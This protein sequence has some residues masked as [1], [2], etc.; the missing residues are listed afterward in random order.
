MNKNA[1]YAAAALAVAVLG[2]SIALVGI[3]RAMVVTNYD[4]SIYIAATALL[5]A[6]T[7]AVTGLI[8]PTKR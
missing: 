5:Y 2:L 3:D 6:V 4:G 8:R 1:I 7:R